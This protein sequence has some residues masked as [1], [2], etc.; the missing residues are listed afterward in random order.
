M[1]NSKGFTLVEI[2]IVIGIIGLLAAIVLPNF[3][4]A[5]ETADR[6]VCISNLKH[7][8]DAKAMWA[9]WEGMASS[10]S[11]AWDDLVP[12]YIR[13]TPRCPASGTYTINTVDAAPTCTQDGHVL[14]K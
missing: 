12:D 11:P 1:K 7:I 4:R 5:K 2:M 13:E 14:L 3:L 9:V 6:N 8:S 10:D